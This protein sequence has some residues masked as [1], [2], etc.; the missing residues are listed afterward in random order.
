[1]HWN[2]ARDTW[3]RPGPGHIVKLRYTSLQHDAGAAE[4]DHPDLPARVPGLPVVACS[5]HSQV[6]VVAAVARHRVP[7]ARIAYVM[8]DGA[9]LPLALSD[10]VHAL[11]ERGVLDI[12]LTAGQAFGGDLEAV[13][14]PSALALARHVAGADL[15]VVGMGPG[16][17]GTASALGTT[18]VEVA[19]IVDAATSMGARV[20]LCCRASSADPRQRHRGVSHHVRT[21][22][23]LA[24]TR[25]T[26]P[27]PAVLAAEL[28][29]ATVLDGPDAAEVLA[30][31][32]LVVTTMGR[33]PGD[34]PAFFAAAAA[35]GEWAAAAVPGRESTDP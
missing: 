12:T 21:I 27:L 17:V 25:P 15:V 31:F 2:L 8:T 29:G 11:R 28:E 33:G 14:V 4:E 34:D 13:A 5:L 23:G 18:A 24:A 30:S 32:D 35:A 20:A 1:V 16:V 10:L 26:L 19:G 9:A 7:G 3:S 6:A 22:L